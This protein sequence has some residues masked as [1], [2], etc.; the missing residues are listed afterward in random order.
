MTKE[1]DLEIDPYLLSRIEKSPYALED[2]INLARILTLELDYINHLNRLNEERSKIEIAF[3][4]RQM[5]LYK[6]LEKAKTDKF[7]LLEK[8]K[9]VI[10]PII[11]LELWNIENNPD[12]LVVEESK[13]SGYLD[14]INLFFVDPRKK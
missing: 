11:L 12:V 1:I 2:L 3:I 14:D 4:K 13:Y 9:N 5:E 7:S 6:N 10:E 8:Y